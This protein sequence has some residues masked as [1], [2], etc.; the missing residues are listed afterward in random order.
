MAR[1]F[2]SPRRRS[3]PASAPL[4]WSLPFD[5]CAA[6]CLFQDCGK[7]ASTLVLV[8]SLSG[9]LK[10]PPRGMGGMFQGLR[11][12][13]ALEASF[14]SDLE[15]LHEL[16]EQDEAPQVIMSSSSNDGGSRT[17]RALNAVTQRLG[18]AQ[19]LSKITPSSL[20]SQ[21]ASDTS[22]SPSEVAVLIV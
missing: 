11:G 16:M 3:A 13:L 7:P 10:E 15:D 18:E 6:L 8:D 17:Q 2:R 5:V 20:P 14:D 19:S 4:W 21:T 12:P 22:L 9:S 1:P